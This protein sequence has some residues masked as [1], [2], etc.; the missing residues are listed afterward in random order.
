MH[1]QIAHHLVDDLT[2]QHIVFG[3]ERDAVK[4]DFIVQMRAGGATGF[5]DEAD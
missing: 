2:F 3:I 4:D 1:T 5:A